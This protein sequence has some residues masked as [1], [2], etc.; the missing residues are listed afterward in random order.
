MLDFVFRVSILRLSISGRHNLAFLFFGESIIH[1][2]YMLAR[3]KHHV[4]VDTEDRSVRI[5]AHVSFYS[6]V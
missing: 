3:F 4:R 5:Q 2:N 1:Q 6:L